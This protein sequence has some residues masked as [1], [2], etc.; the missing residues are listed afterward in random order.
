MTLYFCCDEDGT[1][2]MTMIKHIY[3][4]KSVT[5]WSLQDQES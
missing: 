3:S 4:D 5:A 2:A 1:T